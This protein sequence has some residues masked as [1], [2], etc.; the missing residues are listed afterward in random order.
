MTLQPWVDALPGF[1]VVVA[2]LL[3]P[4][5]LVAWAVGLRGVTAWGASP[6]LSVTVLTLGGIV[7]SRSG[8]RWSTGVAVGATVVA[9]LLA[10]AVGLALRA[11]RSSRPSPERTGVRLAAAGSALLGAVMSLASS[12]PGMGTPDNLVDSPDVVFHLNRVRSMLSSGDTSSLGATGFYPSGF[13]DLAVTALQLHPMPLVTAANMVVLA[14]T[15]VAWPLGCLAMARHVFGPRPAALVA[16][17]V[18][19]ASFVAFPSYLLG[20]G[21]VWA[22]VVGICLVPGTFALV[23]AATTRHTGEAVVGRDVA[24]TALVLALPGQFFGHPTGIVTVAGLAASLGVAALLRV[25]L[26]QPGRPRRRA[27]AALAVAVTLSLVLAAVLPLVSRR[28]AFL[29][30]FSWAPYESVPQAVLAALLHAPHFQPRLWVLSAVVLLGVV[31]AVRRLHAAL[32]AAVGFV[33][34]ATLY[35]LAAAVNS[36]FTAI[37][38]GFWYND[39]VRVAASVPVPAVVLAVAGLGA[40]ARAASQLVARL[41]SSRPATRGV[42]ALLVPALVGAL[43]LVGTGFNDQA[44]KVALVSNYYQPPQRGRQLANADELADLRTLALM[45]PPD[46]GIAGVAA[47]GS[48]L[49]YALTGRRSLF[50]TLSPVRGGDVQTIAGGLDH[51]ASRPDVC[52][53]LE[54]QQ[55]GWAITGKAYYW[56]RSGN[57]DIDRGMVVLAG[58]PGLERVARQGRFVLYKITA[59]GGT[60]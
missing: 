21:V 49:V 29:S 43:F 48:S 45:T 34:F 27:L 36:T 60:L 53:A 57:D 28:I 40:L 6:T 24:V 52:A 4:G 37:F 17:A 19:S 26:E 31:A 5:L 42:G 51:V 16:T 15:A 55:I 58:R 47:N 7:A 56:A 35:V 30:S 22:Q 50:T 9:V 10:G 41:S 8:T 44:A 23:L 13:H 39:A 18:C 32:W 59:C 33:V 3:V 1:G 12:V 46:A 14:V 11:R 54:R 38:T 25:A 2:V 20:W